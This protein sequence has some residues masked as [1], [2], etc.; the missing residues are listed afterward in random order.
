MQD[1]FDIII[2]GSGNA[3]MAA[4]SA[5]RQAG[6]SVAMIEAGAPGGVCAVRGCV[7]K[8][9]L[10]AA[11]QTLHQIDLADKHHI[12]VNG[13]SLDWKR[14]IERKHSFVDGVPASFASGL[15]KN[16]VELIRG[17]ARFT[18]PRSLNV[19]GREIS[20]GKI[21]IAAGSTPRPL[22]IPGAE[23]L[24][25]SDDL[26]E[27]EALPK[28]L[29]FIGGGVIAL[30]FAHVLARA[31]VRVSILEVADRLLPQID[32]DVVR[33]LHAETE[34]LGVDIRTGVKIQEIQKHG[35]CLH[36][37]FEQGGERLTMSADRIV[38]GA[39]R[40]ANVAGLDL[41]A[42]G[43]AMERGAILVDAHLRSATNPDV[44]VAGD[45]LAKAPQLS[46]VASYEG[47]IVARNI[48][49]GDVAKPDYG[50]IPSAVYTTP[51]LASVGL[52][53]AQ[54]AEAGVEV[55]V[56]T[57][58]MTGWRSAMTYA[59]TAAFAKVLVGKADGL[60]KGATII[61][62]GAEEIIHIFAFAMQHGVSADQLKSTVYAYPT[63]SS[64]IKFLV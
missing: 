54:A 30:E 31:G 26:L 43:I 29:I 41:E 58:D 6:K 40:V 12:A 3:G 59:E 62:H 51:A 37:T 44:Y 42:G 1:S 4:A 20:A 11:A 63:F 56:K 9:V 23:H 15:E 28:T 19:D 36:V 64:D 61:G 8:K 35:P 21:L 57:N 24:M 45:A 48:L 16:G 50:S 39:G 38:N 22:P 53:E 14:L 18:G 49:E 52:T 17:A 32:E 33:H 13:V 60:I 46:P 27:M 34:G 5:L 55:E 10:V 25:T 47:R 7:P 2:I